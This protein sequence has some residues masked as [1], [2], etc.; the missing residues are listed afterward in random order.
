MYICL[1]TFDAYTKEFRI[2]VRI[3]LNYIVN[4]QKPYVFLEVFPFSICG[5]LGCLTLLT[6]PFFWIIQ[7]IF[8]RYPRPEKECQSFSLISHDRSLDIVSC[9]WFIFYMFLSLLPLLLQHTP[10]LLLL[11]LYSHGDMICFVH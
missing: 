7:A 5:E 2:R 8:Q 10:P 9:P 11:V 3:Q 4:E 1:A 6:R